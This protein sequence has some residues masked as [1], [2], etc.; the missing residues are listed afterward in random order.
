[1]IVSEPWRYLCRVVIIVIIAFF[2]GCVPKLFQYPIDSGQ[3]KTEKKK[4]ELKKYTDLIETLERKSKPD[5]AVKRYPESEGKPPREYRKDL[6]DPLDDEWK[7]GWMYLSTANL[8]PHAS[9]AEGND[10]ILVPPHLLDSSSQNFSS[11][12]CGPERNTRLSFIHLSDVQLRDET[13]YM[14]NKK[15]TELLDYFSDGFD[16]DHDLVFYDHSYYM[17]LIGM[18]NLMVRDQIARPEFMI[19]TGDAIHM[20]VVSESYNFIQITNELTIPW[21]NVLGN[22]DYAVYGNLKSKTVGVVDPSMLFQTVTSKYNYINMHGEGFQIDKKVYFSPLNAPHDPTK[23][24]TG[25][26]YNG[27]DRNGREFL[28]V[29]DP[30]VRKKKHAR[31]APATIISKLSRQKK[32]RP[33][34]SFWC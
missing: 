17:T 5:I 22:H 30:D 23:D 25:S 1:M 20:G 26:I 4:P 2:A 15:L 28:E 21:Y 27:F 12:N 19:H 33:E 7:A 3:L 29:G 13:V 31:T 9:T 16:Q 8:M 24:E 18:I 34:S 14:F 6:Q 11:G 32:K 10:G